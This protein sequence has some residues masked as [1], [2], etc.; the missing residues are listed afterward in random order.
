MKAA[1]L[2]GIGRMEVRDVPDP[3]IA[4]DDD[5]LMRVEAVGVC[6]SDV[7][8]FKHGRIGAQAVEF[9]V[10]P[11]GD[12]PALSHRAG[13]VRANRTNQQFRQIAGPLEV[14]GDLSQ[15]RHAAVA[16]RLRCLW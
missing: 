9:S 3:P 14:G 8:Y 13:W 15:K 5:I 12:K 4:R 10:K 1:M 7:H 2:T 11:V 16:K 6:G